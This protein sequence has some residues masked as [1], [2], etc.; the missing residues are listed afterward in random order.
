MTSLKGVRIVRVPLAKV[1]DGIK[2]V[3]LNAYNVASKFFA[4]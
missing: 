3:N 2:T 4:Q 1:C